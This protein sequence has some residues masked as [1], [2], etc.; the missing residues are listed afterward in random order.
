MCEILYTSVERNFIMFNFSGIC[1]VFIELMWRGYSH[2]TMFFTG[3]LCFLTLCQIYNKYKNLSFFQKYLFGTLV[4]SSIEFLVGCIVNLF[5][6]MH[7]W[8]YS[9]LP[10]NILGQISLVYSTLWGFLGVFIDYIV[11]Q[12]SC[13]KWYHS[14][15][16]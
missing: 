9:K 15:G 11:N 13:K 16:M 4:I 10:L 8:D 5:F 6:G 14:M 2:Y 1:Y 12:K 3:G 7:V